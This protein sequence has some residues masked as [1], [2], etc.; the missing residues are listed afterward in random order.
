MINLCEIVVTSFGVPMTKEAQLKQSVAAY[1]KD[2]YDANKQITILVRMLEQAKPYANEAIQ[3]KLHSA[4]TE[5]NKTESMKKAVMLATTLL[6]ELENNREAQ[7]AIEFLK[8]KGLYRMLY[9]HPKF[10]GEEVSDD[11][12]LRTLLRS[13]FWGVGISVL[14]VAAFVAT[15]MLGAPFWAVAIASGLFVGASAYVGGIL[16]GVVNDLFATQANLPYFLLGHQPQQ[17]S[18]LRTND[19]V[20]QGVAWGVAATFGP[21]VLAAGAFTVAATIT[22]F[23]VPFATFTMPAVVVALPLIAVGAEFYARK[24]TKEY[25]ELTKNQTVDVG[26]NNYQRTGLDIMCPT[27][28]ERCAWYANSDRNLFG[29]TKVPLIGIGGLVAMITLSAVSMFLPAFLFASPLVAVI[30]PAAVVGGAA[31]TLLGLGAYMH[32]NRNRHIDDRYNLE[33]DNSEVNYNLYLDEDIAYVNDL[34]KDNS[35]SGNALTESANGPA[36]QTVFQSLFQPV[37]KSQDR[38][39]IIQ[40]P[41][42]SQQ[43]YNG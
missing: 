3:E 25:V 23:F 13:G 14:V 2:E 38:P 9:R 28:E 11:D 15:V 26:S 20:A 31:V 41:E 8:Q 6:A 17:S 29:F 7:K 24:K 5:L 18:L 33:F 34:L 4:Q 43:A 40:Q 42:Y 36:V 19:K 30:I 37:E 35:P 32:F 27:N 21:V 39:N 16:Y 1:G 22:A 12:I 10:K